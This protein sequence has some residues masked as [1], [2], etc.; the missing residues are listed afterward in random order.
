MP[1]QVRLAVRDDNAV[2]GPDVHI[3]HLRGFSLEEVDI[4][5]RTGTHASHAASAGQAG[6]RCPVTELIQAGVNVAITT[7]GNSPKTSFDLFQAMRRAK[8]VHQLMA[9]DMFLLPPGKLLEMVTV[10]AARALGRDD[11]IGSLEAGKK[12]DAIVVDLRQ[13]HLSPDFMIVHRLIYE[14]VGNDVEKVVV[15]GRVVMESAV[16]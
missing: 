13:P 11:E 9:R 12:A 15:D 14:A 6:S 4:L 2:L 8:V 3:Q 1:S 7:D 16:C 5:A 10:D